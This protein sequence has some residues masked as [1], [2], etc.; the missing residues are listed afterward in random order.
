MQLICG[1]ATVASRQSKPLDHSDPIVLQMLGAYDM[2][3]IN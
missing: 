2:Q 3:V 1:I